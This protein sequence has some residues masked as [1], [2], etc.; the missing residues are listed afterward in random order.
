M[1]MV[2][3]W[4]D[5]SNVRDFVSGVRTLALHNNAYSTMSRPDEARLR[6]ACQAV[7]WILSAAPDTS[8]CKQPLLGILYSRDTGKRN[9]GDD[10]DYQAAAR[11]R[12]VRIL[13]S[14]KSTEFAWLD[15]RLAQLLDTVIGAMLID[16][17]LQCL[18]RHEPED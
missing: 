14:D 17:W 2:E 3:N 12:N 5:R 9:A 10:R 1:A 13:G 18:L 4:V 16:M 11:H 7:P 8:G 6:R 15:T